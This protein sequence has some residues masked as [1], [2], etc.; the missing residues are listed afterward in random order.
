MSSNPVSEIPGSQPPVI[1]I[2]LDCITG[3][4]VARALHGHGIRVVGIAN[5]ATHFA[6]RTRCVSELVIVDRNG[7]SLL[8]SLR[9]FATENRPVLLPATDTAVAF[10]ARHGAELRTHFRMA[11]PEGTS[12]EEALGKASFAMHAT[13]H[14]IPTPQT[15]IIESLDDLRRATDELHAP[16]VLKPDMKS[17][18]WDALARVKVLQA[19]DAAALTKAYERCRDWSDR[20]VVQEWVAGGDDAMYSY[21]SFIAEDRR[22]VTECV[23]HKIRQWPRLT[24]SGTLSEI[25]EDPEIRETGRALLE[26]LDHRGFATVNMKRDPESGRL[27]VIEANV[28]RPGMGMFVAEAAGIEMTHLAYRSLAGLPLPETPQ[29]RFPNARWVSMKRDF[30]AAAVGWRQ[31]ESSLLDTLRSIRGVRRRAVFSLRDPLPFLYDI[32]RIPGQIYG[33]SS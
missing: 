31:R 10:V 28:G 20:F 25:C 3:L 4:Q 26:S 14:R 24:G 17:E 15:R 6:T 27:F 13:R 33:R 22:V 23:G 16:Y 30:A 21:Y 5:D 19:D 2:G 18:R 1:V 12:I 32:L 11:N 7:S 29:V 8:A 9:K